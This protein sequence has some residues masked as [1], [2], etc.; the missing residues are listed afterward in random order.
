MAKGFGDKVKRKRSKPI[1]PLVIN[2]Q[3]RIRS[4]ELIPGQSSTWDWM[5]GL[6]EEQETRFQQIRDRVSSHTESVDDMAELVL[7]TLSLQEMETNKKQFVESDESICQQVSAL[8]VMAS[9]RELLQAGL[10]EVK[11][12]PRRL[13][14]SDRPFAMRLIKEP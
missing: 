1:F 3:Q 6:D 7:L 5:S 13:V 8:T 11:D 2:L 4:G 9:M 14:D 10:V 12:F